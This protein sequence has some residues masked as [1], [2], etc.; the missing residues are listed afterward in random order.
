MFIHLQELARGIKMR[1]LVDITF[2]VS[3]YFYSL[4]PVFLSITNT[5]TT[6]YIIVSVFVQHLTA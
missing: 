4:H 5:T 2:I 1:C 3:S 6:T